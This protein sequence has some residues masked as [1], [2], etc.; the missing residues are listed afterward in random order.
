MLN[1]NRQSTFK[2][3]RQMRILILKQSDKDKI[4]LLEKSDT[5]NSDKKYISS[6]KYGQKILATTK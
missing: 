5:E 6:L 4:K 3:N 2:Q 1:Q